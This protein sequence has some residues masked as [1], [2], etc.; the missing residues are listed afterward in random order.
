MMG[1]KNKHFHMS[2]WAFQLLAAIIYRHVPG[3]RGLQLKCTRMQQQR[4]LKSFSPL[5]WKNLHW[6]QIRLW[7]CKHLS[8]VTSNNSQYISEISITSNFQSDFFRLLQMD[9]QKD[10]KCCMYMSTWRKLHKWA[11]TTTM[12]CISF[13]WAKLWTYTVCQEIIFNINVFYENINL[14]ELQLNTK[15]RAKMT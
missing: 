14:I 15:T 7:T 2:G 4:S 1:H 3:M 5:Y 9:K 12:I 11:H 8:R 10:G 6:D 13:Y